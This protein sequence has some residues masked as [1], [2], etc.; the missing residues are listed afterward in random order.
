MDDQVKRPIGRPTKYNDELQALA[1]T[2]IFNYKEQGDVIPSRVG[3]CCFLGIAKST[4]FEWADIY[5]E[6]SATLAAI[7]ALQENVALN[8]GLDGTF[9][10]TIVKLVMANHGYTDAQKVDHT[11]NGKDIAPSF[12]TLYG[13]PQE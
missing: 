12:A 5:P 1:D 13:K 11:T 8:R 4:S 10:A 2:Y 7:D 9:N 3:L 6:F